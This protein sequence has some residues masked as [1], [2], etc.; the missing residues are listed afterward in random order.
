MRSDRQPP[1]A[2][3]P[4]PDAAAWDANCLAD[5]TRADPDL[6]ADHRRGR[7]R[8][9]PRDPR[10]VDDAQP[11]AGAVRLSLPDAAGGDEDGH[12]LVHRRRACQGPA[13]RPRRLRLAGAGHGGRADL[14]EAAR[15][16]RPAAQ[17][18]LDPAS[19][20]PTRARC[21]AARRRSTPSRPWR[22]A[23]RPPPRLPRPPRRRRSAGGRAPPAAPATAPIGRRRPGVPSSPRG[24]TSAREVA[25]VAVALRVL[26]PAAGFF[27]SDQA[28]GCRTCFNPQHAESHVPPANQLITWARNSLKSALEQ[29]AGVHGLRRS[30]STP[31]EYAYLEAYINQQRWGAGGGGGGGGAAGGQSFNVP[32]RAAQAAAW[33][34]YVR[35]LRSW[36][37]VRGEGRAAA[38]EAPPRGPPGPRQRPHRRGAGT[39][40][41]HQR[42]P[43]AAARPLPGA[44]PGGG[45]AP[46]PA[47]AARPAPKVAQDLVTAADTFQHCIAGLEED[48]LKA[49]RQL[50]LE[51]DGASLAEFH[52][53]SAN[54]RLRGNPSAA[55]M[56]DVEKHGAQLLAQAIRPPFQD[57]L[58]GLWSIAGSCCGDRYPFISRARLAGQQESYQRGPAPAGSGRR[59]GA[60]PASAR[61]AT[62][63]SSTPSP[64]TP[65]TASSSPAAASTACTTTSRSSR[66]STAASGTSTSWAPA[67]TACAS[68][69]SGSASST[70]TA[71]PRPPRR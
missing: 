53:F 36:Q 13:G 12:G 20:P 49:W 6:P 27:T 57:R 2:S 59:R 30:P 26:A 51:K 63:S 34:D 42:Q 24:S 47:A 41:R 55:R 58:R 18:R 66:S 3:R 28:F 45:D 23:R 56:I 17:Q 22:P 25:S 7:R 54:L 39:V 38:E 4:G 29:D 9:L 37:P 50:A 61:S 43:Q 31:S 71:T 65:S 32:G 40:R 1:G 5:Y 52:S 11:G 16:A 62:R 68:C 70:A 64:S 10:A 21:S 48:P 60:T 69:A 8:L 19:T 46:R 14:P 33:R 67:R 15:R 35:A 44:Q